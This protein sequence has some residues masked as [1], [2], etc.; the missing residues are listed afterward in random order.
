MEFTTVCTYNGWTGSSYWWAS[1]PISGD[2]GCDTFHFKATSWDVNFVSF[3]QE[4]GAILL[5]GVLNSDWVDLV[6][7]GIEDKRKCDR[8]IETTHRNWDKPGLSQQILWEARWEGRAGVSC[9]FRWHFPFT[10]FLQL[11]SDR[12]QGSYFNDYC[13]WQRIE[14]FRQFAFESPVKI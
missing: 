5:R 3:N 13:N 2:I 9:S 11:R 4:D 6:R 12:L 7:K 10:F 8:S 1:D 14:E